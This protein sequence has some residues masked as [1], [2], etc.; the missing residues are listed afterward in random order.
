MST[1]AFAAFGICS[2]NTPW[3]GATYGQSTF[4][5]QI[6]TWLS[7]HVCGAC[8]DCSRGKHL[9]RRGSSSCKSTSDAGQRIQSATVAELAQQVRGAGQ[10]CSVMHGLAVC[11]PWLPPSTGADLLCNNSSV[12]SRTFNGT[13]SLQVACV[14]AALAATV[15]DCSFEAEFRWFHIMAAWQA[16]VPFNC[17]LYSV[18]TCSQVKRL[19]CLLGRTSSSMSSA[20]CTCMQ[21]CRLLP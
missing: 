1:P 20:M 10:T 9:K 16:S 8:A 3:G 17:T 15:S 7:L 11:K 19:A 13:C 5:S 2:P 4:N 21:H 6:L 14:V 18:V 12:C